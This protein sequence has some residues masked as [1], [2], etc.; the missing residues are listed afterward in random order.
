MYFCNFHFLALD[1]HNIRLKHPKRYSY[2][3]STKNNLK[4]AKTGLLIYLIHLSQKSV[5][6]HIDTRDK[7]I[8]SIFS[9]RDL[10]LFHKRCSSKQSNKKYS[11]H[12][13]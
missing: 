2:K 13:Q 6:G 4:T 11:F 5:G 3:I 10:Q 1:L 8:P 9:K 7:L 12:F